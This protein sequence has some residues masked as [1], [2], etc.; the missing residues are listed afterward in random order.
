MVCA[1]HFHCNLRAFACF[2]KRIQFFNSFAKK[3]SD[4]TLIKPI[5]ENI[6]TFSLNGFANLLKKTY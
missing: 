5:A 1:K 4:K 3:L 6:K 2:C